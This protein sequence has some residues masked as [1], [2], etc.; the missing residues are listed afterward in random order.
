M[1]YLIIVRSKHEYA[2]GHI[3][4][5]I[6]TIHTKTEGAANKIVAWLLKNTRPTYVRCEVIEL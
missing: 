5:E 4:Y 3:G 2:E 6:T 1:N